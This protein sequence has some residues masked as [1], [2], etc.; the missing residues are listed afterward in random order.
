MS[1][2]LGLEAYRL[3][4][5]AAVAITAALLAFAL[6]ASPSRPSPRLGLRGLKRQRGTA[7]S[8]LWRAVEPL[9]R[10][11]GVRV[12]G[13]LSESLRA[14]LDQQISLAGDVLG[15]TPEEYVALTLLSAVGG[16]LTALGIN[17]ATGLNLNLALVLCVLL[18]ALLPYLQITGAGQERLVAI[19][20]GLPTVVD[21]LAMTMTAGMDFPGAVRQV[22]E[23][24]PNAD[25][26]IIEELTLLLQGVQIG[27]SRREVLEEL[28]RRAP[29]DAVREFTSA[30][31]Q[32]ELRGNP[33]ADVLQIQATTYRVQRSLKSEEAVSKAGVKMTAPLFLVFGA[34]LLLVLG[35]LIVKMMSMPD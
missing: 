19:S 12:S 31:L 4:T 26:P 13:T 17:A 9:V 20:R 14:R 24:A 21:V 10:W 7:R 8:A 6:A 22:V 25:E 29:C 16:V 35:P 30:V 28:A 11:L 1:A 15:L 32:A 18:G 23:K 27:R 34:V 2:Y 33:L 5:I 3:A